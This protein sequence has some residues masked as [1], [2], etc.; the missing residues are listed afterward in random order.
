MSAAGGGAAEPLVGREA[1]VQDEGIS[2]SVCPSDP[3]HSLINHTDETAYLF[4]CCS[5]DNNA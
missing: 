2:I 4:Y 5:I 3:G 1:C